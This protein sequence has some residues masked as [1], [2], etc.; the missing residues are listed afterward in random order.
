M[1]EESCSRKEYVELLE[2]F[3]Q[4]TLELNSF[5]EMKVR[6]EALLREHA[7]LDVTCTNIR[8]ELFN[9]KNENVQLRKRLEDSKDTLAN[10][11][12]FAKFVSLKEEN[13]ELTSKLKKYSARRR[14]NR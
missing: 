2:R 11:S 1:K 7:E 8:K 3:R 9:C 10:G 12:N 13:R 5:R 14:K 6:H 4:Q